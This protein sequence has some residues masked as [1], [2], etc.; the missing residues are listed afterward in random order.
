VVT[1]ATTYQNP[2]LPEEIRE[3]LEESYGG[4]Q[5]GRQELMGQV[6]LE[7]ENALWTQATIDAARVA[8]DAV[9]DLGHISVGVDPSG[10]AG[11]QGI[12]VSGKSK[13][14]LPPFAMPQQD[15]LILPSLSKPSHQGFVLAD[16]TCR[17]SPQGWGAQAIKAAVDFSADV[18]ICER[19][20]GGD[21]AVEVLRSAAE[22]MGVPIPIRVVWASR[23]KAIRADP[24][25]A[26]TSQGRWHH[27]GEFPELEG[28]MTTWYQE[29]DWSPDRL[30]GAVWTAHDHKL[31]HLGSAG[32]GTVGSQASRQVIG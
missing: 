24:V 26:I 18:V 30:D 21:M 11:E 1:R 13:I 4:T 27:A 28:Q 14:Q 15:G 9:P 10:G 32:V 12:V 5:K 20:Y 19:N 17:K 2:H 16:R 22:A 6:I 23:G 3:A 29:L 7:D 31:V 25:A 8:P